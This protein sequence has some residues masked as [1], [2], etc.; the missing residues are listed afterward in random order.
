MH[1]IWLACAFR[2]FAFKRATETANKH[3]KTVN[4]Q[5]KMTRARLPKAGGEFEFRNA[6]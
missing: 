3:V 2:R 1:V 5:K 6:L 4:S